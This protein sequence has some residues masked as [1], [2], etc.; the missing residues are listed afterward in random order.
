MFGIVIDDGPWAGRDDAKP[1]SYNYPLVGGS[2]PIRAVGDATPGPPAT[3]ITITQ[4]NNDILLHRYRWDVQ[5]V[6]A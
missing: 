5:Q 4:L 3:A 1:T 2:A 6:V